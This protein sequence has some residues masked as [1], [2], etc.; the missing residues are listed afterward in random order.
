MY[1]YRVC[2][3]LFLF[4]YVPARP[5]IYTYGHTLSLHDALPICADRE[6][7]VGGGGAPLL[8]G[9][10][11]HHEVDRAALRQRTMGEI[12]LGQR[13]AADRHRLKI[14]V[15][16]AVVLRVDRQRLAVGHGQLRLLEQRAAD[17]IFARRRGDRIEAPGRED[18]ARKAVGIGKGGAGRVVLRWGA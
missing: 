9:L 13:L 5:E 17:R 6:G 11:A 18:V 8:V 3:L 14:D 10:S 1:S 12:G 7:R 16:V 15:R 2:L 4:F